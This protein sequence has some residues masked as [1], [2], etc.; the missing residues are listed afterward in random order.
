MAL[1]AWP[2]GPQWFLWQLLALN[3]AAAALYRLVPRAGGAFVHAA[4]WA[5]AYPIRFLGALLAASAAVYVPAALIFTP[6]TWYEFGPFAFQFC[7]PLHYTV[8]FFAG[9]AIGAR[10]LERSLLA[11]EG[12]LAKRWGLAA[13]AAGLGFV[14][15]VVP[16]AL[17]EVQY[18]RPGPLALQLAANVGFVL[19]CA[20]GCLF[21]MALV[22]RFARGASRMLDSL[23][24]HAYGMYLVHYVFVVWL[25][26]ALLSSAL[27]AIL[28][29]AIVFTGA[30]LLS[31]GTTLAIGNIPLGAR[32]LGSRQR[33]LPSHAAGAI[34]REGRSAG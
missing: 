29:G 21:V 5:D 17:I 25:Q 28:K 7:R 18:G 12:V 15:W 4:D 14:A 33:P 30:V 8:Y 13:A 32:I 11:T 6:W 27:P 31:W 9:V 24:D 26:Y 2:C 1:P 3:I 23:S 19:C 10:G 34:P 22:L 16:T 20:G